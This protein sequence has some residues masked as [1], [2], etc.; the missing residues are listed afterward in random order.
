[1]ISRR[2]FVGTALAFAAAVVPRGA[3]A[4]ETS[5]GANRSSAEGRLT[6]DAV[7]VLVATLPRVRMVWKPPSAFPPLV[8]IAYYPGRGGDPATPNDAVWLNPEHPELVS[9]RRS[10]LTD[11]IP[12]STE[13]LLASVDMR[14]PGAPS[15]GLELLEPAKRRLAAADLAARVAVIARFTPYPAVD[16]AEFARRAFAF[17]VLRAMTL[18]TGGLE[19]AGAGRDRTRLEPS[20]REFVLATAA[21]QPGESAVR[22]AYEAALRQ[23]ERMRSDSWA[24]RGAFAAPYVDQVAAL[25]GK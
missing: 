24:A 20:I 25:L 7:D 3:G 2:T 9:P 14:P 17:A 18:A 22:T 4:V 21:R 12:L 11:E 10:R 6:L 1:M 16:D 23:D 13:L 15:L 19:R 8:P 5:A